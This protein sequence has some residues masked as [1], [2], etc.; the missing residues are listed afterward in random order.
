V[1]FSGEAVAVTTYTAMEIMVFSLP[2]RIKHDD[3]YNFVCYFL[4]VHISCMVD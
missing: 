2:F 4:A 1:S 3:L